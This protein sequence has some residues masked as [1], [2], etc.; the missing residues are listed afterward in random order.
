[1]RW[2]RPDVTFQSAGATCA[3]WL[4][5]PDGDGPHPI[6]VMAHGFSCV[7][8]QRLDAY[9]ER[10]VGTGL[11]VLLFDYRYFGASGG[12]PRQV[13]DIRS[14]LDDWRAALAHARSIDWVDTGR[15]ALFGS[16]FSG[17]HVVQLASEDH[18]IAAVVSQCPFHDGLATL[19][20]WAGATS[21]SWPATPS[22]TRWVRCSA[23]S[24][25]R[26]GRRPTRPLAVMALPDSRT[27]STRS[28]GPGTLWQNRVAARIGLHVGLYRPGT[29]AGRVA[30][31]TLWGIA[32][33]D[34][35]CPPARTATLAAKAPKG[36]IIHYP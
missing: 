10:F 36:E 32:D 5:R 25:L 11:G 24:P 17:G 22:S 6:V 27:A 20:S 29:K 12:E 18:D 28:R 4:Y 19:A 13:L 33:R 16:S 14:Q 1:M 31:P 26:P 23:A 30:C 3:G 7:R 35:L 21:S 34:T 2:T 9:A 15:V 8:D